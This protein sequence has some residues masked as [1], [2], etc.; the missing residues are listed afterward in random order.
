[1][2]VRLCKIVGIVV[3]QT[4]FSQTHDIQVFTA[5]HGVAHH[6]GL[7]AHPYRHILAAQMHWQVG[8]RHQCTISHM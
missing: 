7:F 2:F 1:M 4:A 8:L 3:Q 6:M 5:A